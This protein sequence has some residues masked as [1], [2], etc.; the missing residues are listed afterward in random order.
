MSLAAHDVLLALAADR[1]ISGSEL[2]TRFGVTRAA[3]WKQIETLRVLGVPISARAGEG[4]RLL[5]PI[6]LLDRREIVAALPS[7][8][9]LRIHEIAVHWQI[10]STNSELLR[11]VDAKAPD[12]AVCLAEVQ[13]HGR[14]RRGRNWHMPL[15]GGLALSL[16]KRFDTSMAALAGLSLAVG[17]ALV[18]AL[19][20]S[21]FEGIGLKWPNDVYVDGR[22]L[23]GILIE[24]GGDAL[25][26]C[27]AVIGIG[28]NLRL[29]VR[30]AER[31]DQPWIDL[32]SLGTIELP[33]RNLLAARLLTRLV[34]VLDQFER[35]GFASFA[36]AFAQYDVL[37]GQPV[38]ISTADR[39]RDGIA[40][41]VDHSGALRVRGNDG[42]FSVDSGDVSVRQRSEQGA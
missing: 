21:G 28:L 11:R 26:P 29:D 1:A 3:V 22:K 37:H 17:V 10:D 9:R 33:S 32:A 35:A 34:E 5:A 7:D 24:L 14:G 12:L 18:R 23:A 20:D 4:Y 40:V 42:E 41:G 6:D 19:E 30:V 16:R 2:A 15:A 27:H 36:D 25:G 31:I 39:Q 38:R 8:L 13:S